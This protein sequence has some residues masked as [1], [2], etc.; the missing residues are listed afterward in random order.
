M[1]S[2]ASRSV[3]VAF[4]IA[5]A[6]QSRQD[7]DG[8]R[9]S[10]E[11][12]GDAGKKVAQSLTTNFAQLEAA[13][14]SVGRKYDEGALITERDGRKILEIQER[15][16]EIVERGFKDIANAPA[17]IQE[18]YAKANAQAAAATSVIARQ[19]DAI[20]D[21]KESL[22][23]GQIAWTGLGDAANKAMGKYGAAQVQVAAFFA[24][25]REGVQIGNQIAD[26]IGT[27]K[28]AWN[29]FVSDLKT[30]G[31]EVQS[32]LNNI[33]A[34]VVNLNEAFTSGDLTRAK[35]NVADFARE[36]EA[37]AGKWTY[38]G[39]ALKG[40][41]SLLDAHVN[42]MKEWR[43][44]EEDLVRIGGQRDAFL[45]AGKH[46]VDIFNETLKEHEG[47][48]KATADALDALLPHITAYKEKLEAAKQVVH[49]HDELLKKQIEDE[50]HL[51]EAHEAEIRK[52][53]ELVAAIGTE[54]G[55]RKH[56]HDTV[57]GE[58]NDLANLDTAHDGT[59]ESVQNVAGHLAELTT[60]FESNEP[61]IKKEI[62]RLKEL[63]NTTVGLSD[64]TK[65][66]IET[67]AASEEEIKRLEAANQQLQEELKHT[68]KSF[69]ELSSDEIE[70][71]RAKE[72]QLVENQNLIAAAKERVEAEARQ[73]A[74]QQ[75]TTE[76]TNQATIT[77][78]DG[79]TVIE[80]NTKSTVELT[81]ATE[82]H[83]TKI[84][85]AAG[86]AEHAAEST[87]K[88]TTT[89]EDG[90]K[91]ISNTGEAAE[92][93][94]EGIKGLSGHV[95]TLSDATS[96]AKDPTET[97]K[98]VVHELGEEFGKT[99]SNIDA[100]IAKLGDLEKAYKSATTS[101]NELARAQKIVEGG[102]DDVG[103]SP[104]PA[105]STP[106]APVPRGMS[107]AK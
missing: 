53:G 24:A 50:K 34:S 28:T 97:F 51:I 56:L 44:A 7:I 67:I 90:K 36:V 20:K 17:E 6:D 26:A 103:T 74:A 61:A 19:T 72:R 49:E 54:D 18:A 105:S 101:A 75:A 10:A 8:I 96:K 66:H 5:G 31:A 57:T 98:K 94:G 85:N 107:P 32:S 40:Y 84:S 93:A 25:L 38:S 106:A 68:G 76:A 52:I 60:Q 30:K 2:T 21:N 55:A 45:A 69:D 22:Q 92:H 11:N 9:K 81:K 80:N 99:N 15:I 77:Y 1:S 39:A 88:L 95:G 86:E 64:T 16:N 47:D 46:G 100:H 78:K 102:T 35:A 65:K 83:G 27:D 48:L 104:P 41:T 42:V 82:D 58:I 87:A 13:T 33:I 73:L 63:E 4:S 23:E 37:F 29:D 62:D 59:S 14:E 91:V 79:K 71:L 70:N 43:G 3:S 12:F 89:L